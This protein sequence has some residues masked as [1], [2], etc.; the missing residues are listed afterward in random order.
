M[1]VI[2]I[3]IINSR[4]TEGRTS[5]AA[6]RLQQ[7]SHAIEFEMAVDPAQHVVGGNLI[8]KAEVGEELPDI[9]SSLNPPQVNA[10][11]E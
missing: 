9:P 7:R 10:T 3:R 2:S 11:I 4:S 5:G 1:P 6:E 8:I